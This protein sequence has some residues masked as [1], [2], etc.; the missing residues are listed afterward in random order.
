M[1]ICCLCY[2]IHFISCFGLPSAVPGAL[3]VGFE[4]SIIYYPIAEESDVG[5]A[6]ATSQRFTITNTISKP[7]GKTNKF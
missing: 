2:T 4:D 3:L 1:N 7:I 5:D 6:L